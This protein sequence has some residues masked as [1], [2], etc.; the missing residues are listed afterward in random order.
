MTKSKRTVSALELQPKM[1]TKCHACGSIDHNFASCL[2]R[3]L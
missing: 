3:L 2:G 1:K